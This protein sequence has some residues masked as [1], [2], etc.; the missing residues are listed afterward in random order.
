MDLTSEVPDDEETSDDSA[1]TAAWE[2]SAGTPAPDDETSDLAHALLLSLY[3]HTGNRVSARPAHLVAGHLP[4]DHAPLRAFASE[5]YQDAYRLRLRPVCLELID[6]FGL[7]TFVD[8][9]ERIA[10]QHGF[11]RTGSE[12]KKRVWASARR[13]AAPHK[14]GTRWSRHLLAGTH[15]SVGVRSLP[16]QRGRWCRAAVAFRAICGAAR[17]GDGRG[18]ERA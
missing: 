15:G 2:S 14:Q 6:T 16:W 18:P 10:R 13:P 9:A 4:T 17:T 3:G 5:F 1:P 7:I 11:L 8:L 12:I